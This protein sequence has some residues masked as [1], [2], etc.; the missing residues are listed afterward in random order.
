MRK[1][2]HSKSFF[3]LQSKLL[4]FAQC[5]NRKTPWL[6]SVK[7]ILGIQKIA[8]AAIARPL[9]TYE[10]DE[11]L[12]NVKT[13]HLSRRL[14]ELAQ[15]N[16]T[17]PNI[18]ILAVECLGDVIAME[19]IGRYIRKMAPH[20]TIHWIVRNAYAEVLEYAPFIDEL[21]T[22]QSLS[23]GYD[24]LQHESNNPNSITINCHM[25]GTGCALTKRIIRN[26][27]NPKINFF[28]YYSLGTLLN[29]FSL[30]AGLPMLEEDPVFYLSPNKPFPFSIQTPYIV[31][32]CHSNDK[33]RDWTDKKWNE[34]AEYVMTLDHTVIEVGLSRTI[35]TQN[36]HYTD[37]TGKQSLQQVAQVIKKAELFIGIDSSFAHFAHALHTKAIILLGK[38]S[39]YTQYMPYSGKFANSESFS[40]IRAQKGKHASSIPTSEVL[41]YVNKAILIHPQK[42]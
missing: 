27:T 28:T 14:S 25:D 5:V 3:K 33:Q 8:T 20:G 40:I 17:N 1:I 2:K 4:W 26:Q 42:H 24:I 18:F 23:D 39:H 21:I 6:N 37:F 13:D 7:R 29:A 34:L 16:I 35:S 9:S 15:R 19:P 12:S 31:I 36:S 41:Q 32:H 11:I 38:Y 10:I 30:S 22:V